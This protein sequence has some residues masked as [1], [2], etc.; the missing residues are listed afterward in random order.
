LN[1]SPRFPDCRD[2]VKEMVMK[3]IVN[4]ALCEGNG[5]CAKEAPERFAT[6]RDTICRFSRRRSAKSFAQRRLRRSVPAR[7][8]RCVWSN[9]L[10]IMG[11]I[12]RE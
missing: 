9:R 1:G 8:T 3:V 7:S 5:N 4:R 2:V 10:N 11:M 12:G 6:D